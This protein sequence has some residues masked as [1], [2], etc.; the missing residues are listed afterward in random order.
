MIIGIKGCRWLNR[1]AAEES[2]LWMYVLEHRLAA[3]L[4]QLKAEFFR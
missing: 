1:S 3:L 2:R 4:A